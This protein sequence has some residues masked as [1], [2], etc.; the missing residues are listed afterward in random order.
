MFLLVCLHH[1]NDIFVS[2]MIKFLSIYELNKCRESNI[3][4][5]LQLSHIP[6]FYT[7]TWTSGYAMF[8]N[9]SYA[10]IL[11]TYFSSFSTLVKILNTSLK[12]CLF[13]T[14]TFSLILAKTYFPPYSFWVL[15]NSIKNS[16]RGV[17]TKL[18][19]I[20]PTLPY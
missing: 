7:L 4:R 10:L 16:W 13:I 14:T 11:F 6:L 15:K 3:I 5:W 18:Q 17:S 2:E 12:M 9:I 8:F 1:W 19:K 20:L